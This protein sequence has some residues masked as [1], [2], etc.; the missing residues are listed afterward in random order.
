MTS[1]NNMG[2]LLLIRVAVIMTV[3]MPRHHT[4]MTLCIPKQNTV[5]RG[6]RLLASRARLPRQV[7]R[8]TIDTTLNL[9]SIICFLGKPEYYATLGEK[10]LL[11]NI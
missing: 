1:V 2:I 3:D 4:I 6:P 5:T 11:F 7:I 9:R 10:D 8:M